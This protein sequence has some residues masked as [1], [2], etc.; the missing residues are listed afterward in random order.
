MMSKLT[1]P[2]DTNVRECISFTHNTHT[3]IE[4]FT[5]PKKNY[6]DFPAVTEEICFLS[7]GRLSYSPDVACNIHVGLL[8]YLYPSK[9]L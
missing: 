3:H 1:G 2:K 5:K 6:M 7:L 9:S 4:I 8:V